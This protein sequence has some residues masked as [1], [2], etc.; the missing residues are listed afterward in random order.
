[1]FV[2]VLIIIITASALG[3]VA[4]SLTN[5]GKSASW[6]QFY[7]KGKDAGF[8]FKEIELLRRLAVKSNLEDPVSLFWSQNQLDVCIRSLVRSLHMTGEDSETGSQDFLSKLYDYRKKIEMDK[9]RIKNGI[10]NSRQIS[11]GQNLRILV[12]GSGVFKSQIVK[13][14]NQYLAISRPVS[15]KLPGTFSWQGLK[16][17]VYFWREDDAGYVFDS[18]VLDEV[19][20][21]GIASLKI[22]HSDSL[23]RTQKRKSVRVKLHKSAFLYLITNEEEA[24]RIEVNPGLKCFLEDLSD[25]G[26][27]VTIG[28]KAAAGLRIKV[29]FAL[30]NIPIIM[31]GTVRSV[32]YKEDLNRS[33]LHIEADPLPIEIRNQILGEVF[34][35][36]PEEEEDL[37]F[38]LLDE[39]AEGIIASAEAGAGGGDESARE[40][41]VENAENVE[42]I[43]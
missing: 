36:L 5:K 8:G 2:P 27:A 31:I 9:P 7:A 15:N 40:G 4:L 32:E 29:Q 43:V 28:G 16:I 21:K 26:C 14:T 35:M 1:M 20:S 41:V 22:S 23:F 11:D 12:S 3:M 30:N 39:E 37:P 33:L 17:S 18:E 6:L 24:A 25:T 10:S 34:G 42:N 38:R 13:N 19:F